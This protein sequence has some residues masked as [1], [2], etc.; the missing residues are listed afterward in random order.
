MASSC[1]Q[2]S[3]WFALTVGVASGRRRRHHRRLVGR[4]IF[5]RRAGGLEP[6]AR[7]DGGGRFQ[8]PACDHDPPRFGRHTQRPVAGTE[9][10]PELRAGH[11]HAVR[12]HFELPSRLAGL[13]MSDGGVHDALLHE[14]PGGGGVQREHP[15]PS[16]VAQHQRAPV[17]EGDRHDP[18]VVAS[19]T[20]P[21]S[22]G[23]ASPISKVGGRVQIQSAAAPAATD[24]EKASS[25]DRRR[26]TL[27]DQRRKR[28]G[29]LRRSAFSRTA[30]RVRRSSSPASGSSASTSRTRLAMSSKPSFRSIAFLP[31][32]IAP[33]PAADE[34]PP[35]SAPLP[36]PAFA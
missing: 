31:R 33:V 21:N 35:R 10:D 22:P 6:L 34:R 16:A 11:C 15:N 28:D 9:R 32:A 29:I 5:G 4:G 36:V 23:R 25:N 18:A 2:R 8:A 1:R 27:G 17:G 3:I 19:T 13:A 7:S 14:H 12:A 20:S 26:G 30:E 24:A